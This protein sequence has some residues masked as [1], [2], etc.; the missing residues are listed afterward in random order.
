MPKSSSSILIPKIMKLQGATNLHGWRRIVKTFLIIRGVW[1]VV[2]CE[3]KNLGE[4]KA[5]AN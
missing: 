3:T 1:K 2:S 5:A 4:D